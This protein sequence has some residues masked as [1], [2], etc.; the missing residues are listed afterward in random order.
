MVRVAL[1]DAP[2]NEAG[3]LLKRA[4]A[5]HGGLEHVRYPPL[6]VCSGIARICLATNILGQD[7]QM[8]VTCTR[9]FVHSAQ[10]TVAVQLGLNEAQTKA[11]LGSAASHGLCYT[12][13]GAAAAAAAATAAA[14]AADAASAAAAAVASAPNAAPDTVAAAAANADAAAATAATAAAAFTAA[15]RLKCEMGSGLAMHPSA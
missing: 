2:T 14:A 4:M 7:V 3:Q 12:R 9:H 5:E 10:L 13:H 15:R 8:A 11:R 6:L 1:G